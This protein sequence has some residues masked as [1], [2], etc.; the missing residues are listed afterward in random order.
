VSRVFVLDDAVGIT[1]AL[2]ELCAEIDAGRVRALVLV[3]AGQDGGLEP[4]WGAERSVG[5][6][7]GTILRGMVAYVGALMD[8]EALKATE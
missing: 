5:A 3:V 8:R 7:A 2:E 6:H 4:W 1:A